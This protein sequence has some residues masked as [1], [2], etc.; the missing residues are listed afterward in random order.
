MPWPVLQV[1]GQLYFPVA[2]HSL[3]LQARPNLE[4]PHADLMFSNIIINHLSTLPCARPVLMSL[5]QQ[6]PPDQ[7]SY[8]V[9]EPRAQAVCKPTSSR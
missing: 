8:A 3:I 2:P 1:T 6:L 9:L 5:C 4:T 7:N